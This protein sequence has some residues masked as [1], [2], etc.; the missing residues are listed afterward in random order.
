M[1]QVKIKSIF[2][3][4]ILDSRGNPTIEADCLLADGSFGRAAVPSGAS[5]GE[6]EAVELRDG[7][8]KRYLGK[9]VCKAVRNTNT[10]IAKALK[11]KNAFDQKAV[12]E[13]MIKLD[14]TANKS[15]LGANA[16]LAASMAVCRAAAVSRGVSLFRHIGSLHGN[17]KFTLPVPMANIINGGKHADNKIDFQE[18]MIAPVGAP[19]FSEGLRWITEIFHG[20]KTILKK[21]GH[22]TAVGDEGGFAPNLGNEESLDVIMEA[23]AASGYK[24]GKQI[25]IALDCAS[26][27]LFDEGGR[28]GYKFWKSNPG[29]IFSA[30]EMIGIY[31]AWVKKYPIYSIEDGLD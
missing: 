26:S 4:E 17:K 24:A 16:T 1:K 28:K 20:L 3:R 11:G 31:A 15:R 2:A 13:L 7:D 10:E 8:K 14:G 19:S 27:E 6:F 9:G 25:K 22:V 30:D 5:T 23:I 21:K 18:F 29:R 12:D